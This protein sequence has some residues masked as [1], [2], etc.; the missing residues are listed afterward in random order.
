[1]PPIDLDRFRA[2]GQAVANRPRAKRPPRHRAGLWFVW[3]PIPGEWIGPA[4]ALPG[5][6]LAV[7]LAVWFVAGKAKCRTV[8]LSTESLR[9]FSVGRRA[10]YRGLRALERAGL[11]AVERHA[12]RCPVVTILET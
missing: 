8:K 9:W 12:G 4:A 2:N 7:A 1:M 3:G 5:K 6:A 10:A 11:V